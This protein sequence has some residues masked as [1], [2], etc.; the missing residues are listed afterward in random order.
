MS[1]SNPWRDGSPGSGDTRLP[2]FDAAQGAAEPQAMASVSPH[3]QQPFGRPAQFVEQAPD[4]Q[5]PYA[6][7]DQHVQT[8]GYIPP[9]LSKRMS[10]GAKVTLGCGIAIIVV[11]V[12]MLASCFAVTSS[13][14]S[15]ID[16]AADDYSSASNP[17]AVGTPLPS[18]ASVSS[19]SEDFDLEIVAVETGVTAVSE[20]FFSATPNGEFITVEL[21]LTNLTDETLTIAASSFVLTD[22]EGR[23]FM[24]SDDPGI[25]IGALKNGFVQEQLPPGITM[26]GTVAFDVPI[27]TDPTSVGL[28]PTS[29][30]L[31]A[32]TVKPS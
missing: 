2:D 9:H 19:T 1:H 25:L 10:T 32:V 21:M 17:V 12:L 16:D 30:E 22:A 31:E 4:G 20:P 13:V 28:S 15:A 18:F 23:S 27:G 24:P 7:Q 3:G 29:D 11:A 6:A 26:S 8:F 5:G 14:S